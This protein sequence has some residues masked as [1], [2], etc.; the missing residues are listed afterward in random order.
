MCVC[1]CVRMFRLTSY[2]KILLGD[3]LCMDIPQLLFIGLVLFVN[4]II[5][6]T[7]DRI[8]KAFGGGGVNSDW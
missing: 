7:R 6:F 2:E 3:G 8:S 5:S 1:V 4:K